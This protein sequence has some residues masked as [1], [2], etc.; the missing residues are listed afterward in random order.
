[1]FRKCVRR[2][3]FFVD[4]MSVKWYNGHEKAQK[5]HNKSTQ[6]AG[7]TL[8][9]AVLRDN[10]IISLPD[11]LEKDICLKNY[12]EEI[13]SNCVGHPCENADTKFVCRYVALGPSHQN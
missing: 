10:F 4:N 2:I 5:Q 11:D 8:L 6:E 7:E 9:R 3:F 12:G 13:A 1:M